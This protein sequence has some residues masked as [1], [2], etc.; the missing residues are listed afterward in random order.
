MD[1]LPLARQALAQN[2]VNESKVLLCMATGTM[3]GSRH[4][5][6]CCWSACWPELLLLSLTEPYNCCWQH[7]PSSQNHQIYGLRLP[8][9]WAAR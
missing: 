6:V 3:H 8:Q 5:D 9:R 2:Q 1:L 7:H 4:L